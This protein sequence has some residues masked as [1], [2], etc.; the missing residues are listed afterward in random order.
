[1]E[2]GPL[3][4][5]GMRVSLAGLGTGGANRF[6]QARGAGEREARRLVRGALDLGVNY[7]DTAQNYGMS[8]N[9]LGA[10]LAGV[11]RSEYLVATKYAY[12][13]PDGSL[14]A[15]ADVEA[16]IRASL[17]RLR[18][19]CI[20]VFQVHSLARA[21]YDEVA[22]RHVPVLE[23]AR[24]AG[25]IRAIGVTESF[26]GD[27]PRHEAL[28]HAV[29]HGNFDVVMVGYN[30]LHQTAER[31]VLPVAQRRGIGV[32][33]MAA[34]RRVL[35]SRELLE[36]L[37]AELKESGRIDAGSVPDIDPL[38]WLVGGAS[39][40]VPSACYRYVAGQSAVSTVLTGTFD[41]AHLIENVEAIGTG[42]L[43]PEQVT[44]LRDAFGHL[45]LGLG[46]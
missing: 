12:R 2:Y 41:L 5:T 20:D 29:D 24:E 19:E 33:V 34:V 14:L 11:A 46:R 21:D 32:V 43:P 6:G 35:G 10:A 42:P 39:P 1:M 45:D 26:A 18:V 7:F 16:A 44:R 38:G 22:S 31:H 40:S 4:S 3:G 28:E 37:I 15:E 27:D 23:R 36:G 13:H 8:E 9:L 25:L 17:R 30:V